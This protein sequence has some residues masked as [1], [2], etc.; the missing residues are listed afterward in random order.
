[1]FSCDKYT[2][3]GLMGLFISL[4]IAGCSETKAAQCEKFIQEVNRGTSLLEKNK[5]SQVTT[6][7]QLSKDLGEISKSIQG[8]NFQDE[9]LKEYQTQFTKIFSTFSENIE[10][11][12]KALGAAKNAQADPTGRNQV[13]QSRSDIDAAF[14][15]VEKAAKESDQLANKLNKYCSQVE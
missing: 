8:L 9:T 14:K 6:S 10:K 15:V 11:A 3:I 2:V 13:K 4:A 7:L 5:G 1:M 12:G